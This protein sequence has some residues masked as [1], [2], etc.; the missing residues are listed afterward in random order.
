MR[1]KVI[2]LGPLPPPYGGVS[3]FMDAAFERLKGDGA[4]MWAL[5]GDASAPE[6]R[7]RF[8]KHRRFGIIPALLS[9]GR[10]ARI[11]DA[12]HFHLEYPNKFLLPVWLAA[13]RALRFE[14]VKIVL[15]GSLPTRHARFRPAQLRRFRAAVAAVDEFVVVHEDLRRWL[16]DEIKVRQRVSVIPCLLPVPRKNY[17]APL[18]PEIE[19]ALASYLRRPRRVCSVGVFIREYGFADAARAVELLRAS[20]GEDIG[21]VLLDGTFARDETYREETL[22]GR[23]W[24]TVV[25]NV[26]NPQVYQILKRGDAFVR[27][28]GLES[29]GISRVEALWCGVP[30]VA[31]RAGETRGLLLYDYGDPEGLAAQLRVALDAPPRDDIAHWA[32]VYRREAEDNLEALRRV[33]FAE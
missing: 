16:Q 12:T 2:L 25:E 13:R 8:V 24:I 7:L 28:F 19:F 11:L 30:V 14:W 15:D 9:G 18:A 27:A 1:R 33:A 31:T 26:P 21:L 22:R 17:D 20:S 29:Y 10:G 3:V 6:A 4:Q 23:E 32:E 5:F